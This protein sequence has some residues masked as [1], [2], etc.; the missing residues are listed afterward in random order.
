IVI[1]GPPDSPYEKGTFRLD[2]HIPD[3][4]P[5]NPPTIKFKTMIYHPNVD[6]GGTICLS[7]LKMIEADG[8]KPSLSIGAALKSLQ[9]LMGEPNPHD[10]LDAE[11]AKEFQFD[12]ALFMRKAKEFTIKYATGDQTNVDTVSFF[13]F[14]YLFIYYEKKSY[15]YKTL[16][17]I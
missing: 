6:E 11:I 10:P 7:I 15:P 3:E 1:K 8:W 5:F 4:Y 17:I 14:F 12:N 16:N 2:I 9:I 13:F